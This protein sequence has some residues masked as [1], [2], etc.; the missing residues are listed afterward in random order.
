MTTELGEFLRSRRAAISPEE[1]GLVSYGA[2]RVPGLRREELAMLAGVS[3][4]YYTRLERADHHN[5]SD[6]VIDS[7]ARALRLG[8]EEH[9]HLRR[10]ARPGTAAPAR[11]RV[12][13]P[14]PS[15]ARLIQATSGP[16]LLI[17]HRNDVLAWNRLGHLL[18]APDLPFEQTE[19][20]ENRP[21]MTR[22]F[23]LEPKT[24]D[25]WVDQ[26]A[27]ASSHVGFL[28]YSSGL[29][30][31]DHRLSCMVGELTQKSDEFAEL[32]AQHPI[33]DCGYG[34][35]KFQHPIV[36]RFDLEYEAPV[37]PETS[38]RMCLYHAEAGSPAADALELLDRL[39]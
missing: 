10:L 5:A 28:R 27:I 15:T 22:R 4:T 23:F 1:A 18:M 3:P 11:Y 2:R 20:V 39:G 7:L 21:N 24:R 17:D 25:L 8:P 37:M 9:D 38:H 26:A 13:R 31:D 14:R 12:E 29:H 36:G 34:V 19:D 33:N 32:W 6:A 16:A 35:K 30:P